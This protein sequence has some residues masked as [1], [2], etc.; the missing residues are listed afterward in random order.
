MLNAVRLQVSTSKPY[1]DIGEHH[2]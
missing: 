1:G 2:W